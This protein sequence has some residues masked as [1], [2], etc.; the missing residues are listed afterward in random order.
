MV[1]GCSKLSTR[2][3]NETRKIIAQKSLSYLF[4]D[5]SVENLRKVHDGLKNKTMPRSDTILIIQDAFIDKMYKDMSETSKLKLCSAPFN[6]ETLS[7]MRCNQFFTNWN[8]QNR[9]TNQCIYV[10]NALTCGNLKPFLW[11]PERHRRNLK[12]SSAL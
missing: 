11:S 5:A 10:I 7:L 1:S 2:V 4:S 9:P 3:S 6:T 8:P 12:I